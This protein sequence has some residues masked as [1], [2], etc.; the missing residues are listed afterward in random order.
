MILLP[1]AW[2]PFVHGCAHPSTIDSDLVA[3]ALRLEASDKA[4]KNRR[5]ERSKPRVEAQK[6]AR[7]AQQERDRLQ[8]EFH[9][10]LQVSS[11]NKFYWKQMLDRG[12]HPLQ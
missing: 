5:K 7:A 4:A 1:K 9:F 11:K 3:R 8:K 12:R 6:S 2:A 10:R